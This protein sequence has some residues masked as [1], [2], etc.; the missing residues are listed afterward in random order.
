MLHILFET[1]GL[2]IVSLGTVI[3]LKLGEG[4]RNEA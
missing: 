2:D 3:Q 1:V 4:E